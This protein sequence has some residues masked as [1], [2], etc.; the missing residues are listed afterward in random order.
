M[1]SLFRFNG[2]GN[3]RTVPVWGCVCAACERARRDSSYCRGACSAVLETDT[4]RLLIDAG[5]PDL[6]QRYAPADISAIMLTHYHMDHVMGLFHLRWGKNCEIPVHGPDD[7]QGCDDLFKH[8][9]VLKFQAPLRPFEARRLGPFE[10]TALPLNHSKPTLGYLFHNWTDGS[11]G[12]RLAYLTDTLGLPA[13]TKGF[14][15]ANQ[16]DVMI[17]D[18]SHPPRPDPRNH[19]DL[20]IALGLIDAIQPEQ[21]FLTHIGHELDEY[22]M[23]RPSLPANVRIAQD[24]QVLDLSAASAS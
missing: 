5:Q 21:A 3:A 16:P 4:Y 23:N 15:M 1:S 11:D 19:N 13:D 14:L 20:T 7:P 9:G 6:C 8:P 18:C 2:T 17:L 10:V 22:L 24:G 12:R